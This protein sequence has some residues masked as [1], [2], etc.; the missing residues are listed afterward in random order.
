MRKVYLAGPD[1]FFPDALAFMA[2]KAE[3]AAKYGLKGLNPGDNILEF[4][5][6]PEQH[7]YAI[8]A[9]DEALMNE[10]DAIIANLTP[11]RGVSA[12]AGTVY[13]LGYMAAQGKA[14]F[15]Y[16]NDARPFSDRIG[17]WNSEAKALHMPGEAGLR[18]EN[19]QFADNLMLVGGIVRRGGTFLV[20]DEAPERRFSSLVAF[21]KCCKLLAD[22]FAG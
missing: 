16:T 19:F 4:K 3:I 20:E 22:H 10:A 13:E 9:A 11:F 6:T 14:L 7:G 15:A 5:T 12:D 18:A 17:I 2:K 1:V 8:N 21:E